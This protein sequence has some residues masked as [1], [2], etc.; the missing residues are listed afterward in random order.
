M[1]FIA[2][3]FSFCTH[4]DL[5]N[6]FVQEPQ[7]SLGASVFRDMGMEIVIPRSSGILEG[8]RNQSMGSNDVRIELPQNWY[9]NNEFLGFALYY[10][11]LVTSEFELYCM[12]AIGANY[13]S[14]VVDTLLI[15]YQC[16][17]PDDDDGSVSDLVWVTY[18]PKHAIKKQCHSNQWTHSLPSTICEL[19]SLT[20]LSCSGYSKLSFQK[21]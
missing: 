9:E 15:K 12:L 16:D 21:S 10:C 7:I 17:C 14:K 2:R 20:T 13:Q 11:V 19:K 1:I 3:A 8:T 6:A 4:W 18:Y 5:H